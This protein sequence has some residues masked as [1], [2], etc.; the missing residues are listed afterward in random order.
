MRILIAPL[1]WGLGHATRC[2]P[3]IERYRRNGHEIILG[4]D[5]DSL[6]YLKRRYPTLR[7]VPLA[8]LSVHYSASKHQLPALLRMLPDF[9]RFIREDRRRL[10]ELQAQ[11]HF[12]LVISDNRFGLYHPQPVCVYLTHQLQIRLPLLWRWAESLATRLHAFY[13]M[14]FDEIW[15]PDYADPSHNLSGYLGHPNPSNIELLLKLKLKYKGPLSRFSL[16]ESQAA[17]SPSE[18]YDVVAVLSGPEPQRSLLEAEIIRRYEHTDKR[19]LIVRGRM[20][21]PMTRASHRNITLVPRL[22]DKE[23]ATAL[24]SCQ[25]IIARSGYS[26]IMDLEA[27]GLLSSPKVEL[28]PTPGQSE[29][30]YLSTLR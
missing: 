18:P 26:T 2:V 13:Y 10:S 16:P 27:L 30:E 5:G 28:I 6:L 29:Q 20:Q 25:H 17:E 14:S 21:G 24:S 12:D 9:I 1:N 7:V 22:E 4:G 15:V 19:V 11:Y 3:L 8:S 23:L